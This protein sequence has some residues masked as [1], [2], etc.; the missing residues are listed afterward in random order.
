M[1]KP[2]NVFSYFTSDKEMLAQIESELS[3]SQIDINAFGPIIQHIRTSFQSELSK[4]KEESEIARSADPFNI[5]DV[6]AVS[7]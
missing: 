1:L 4:M 5:N 7:V 6:N 3:R 2:E